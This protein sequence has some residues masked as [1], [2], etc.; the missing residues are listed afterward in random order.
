MICSTTDLK[1]QDFRG[2]TEQG[3]GIS[4]PE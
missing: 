1:M 2:F 3:D 4:W